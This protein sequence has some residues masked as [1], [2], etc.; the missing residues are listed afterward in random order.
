MLWHS[1]I[2]YQSQKRRIKSYLRVV[3]DQVAHYNQ[4]EFVTI[5]EDLLSNL[6]PHVSLVAKNEHGSRNKPTKWDTLEENE[7][8]RSGGTFLFAF[9]RNTSI[10]G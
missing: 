6:S 8:K 9:S 3:E 2:S 5:V 4:V 1:V 7:V 10:S